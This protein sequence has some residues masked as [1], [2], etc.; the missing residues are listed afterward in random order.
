MSLSREFRAT[1]G[2][3]IQILC[4]PG[5]WLF[6]FL[7]SSIIRMIVAVRAQMRSMPAGVHNGSLM[8]VLQA[9]TFGGRKG[10]ALA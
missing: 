4:R 8:S 5:L 9:E 2:R 10:P 7:F 6:S 1:C 3:A